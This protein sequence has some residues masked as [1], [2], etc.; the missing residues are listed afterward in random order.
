MSNDYLDNHVRR[1]VAEALRNAGVGETN[2]GAEI[3]YMLP[4]E[5]VRAYEELYYRSLNMSKA[6]GGLSGSVDGGKMTEKDERISGNRTRGIL[7]GEE[8]EVE[9]GDM[10]KR[11][12]ESLSKKKARL[13]EG[14]D[15]RKSGGLH[16]RQGR[17]KGAGGKRFVGPGRDAW[18]LD[19]NMLDLKNRVDRKLKRLIADVA[20]KTVETEGV[21]YGVMLGDESGSGSGSGGNHGSRGGRENLMERS[22]GDIPGGIEVDKNGRKR[23]SHCGKYLKGDFVRCPYPHA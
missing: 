13:L 7:E 12:F 17:G 22:Q 8:D 15:K 10:S 20:R 9:V 19:E 21:T 18:V 4:K 6:G 11:E 5:F 1:R 2:V 23:C 3:L 16:T 14:Q